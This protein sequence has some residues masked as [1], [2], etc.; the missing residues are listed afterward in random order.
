[1]ANMLNASVTLF[2]CL[3]QVKHMLWFL[4]AKDSFRFNCFIIFLTVK[5][6]EEEMV[7]LYYIK[8]YYI[9]YLFVY[10]VPGVRPSVTTLPSAA[11]RRSEQGGCHIPH[12]VAE[13]VGNLLSCR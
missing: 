9:D 12:F 6:E 13:V 1:M 8:L 10:N 4:S 5:N 2:M 7:C 11:R 3:I